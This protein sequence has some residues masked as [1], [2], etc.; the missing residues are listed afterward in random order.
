MTRRASPAAK[1]EEVVIATAESPCGRK[2]EV[3][4]G[5]PCVDAKL[6]QY[7]PDPERDDGRCTWHGQLHDYRAT[8]DRNILFNRGLCGED[9]IGPRMGQLCTGKHHDECEVGRKLSESAAAR[10]AP[11]KKRTPHEMALGLGGGE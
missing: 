4:I 8:G 10:A 1:R 6:C 3:K 5:T 9:E 7:R 2:I 11:V